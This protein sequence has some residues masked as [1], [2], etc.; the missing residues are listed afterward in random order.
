MKK[1]AVAAI[2]AVLIAGCSSQAQTFDAVPGQT[3][4]SYDL[5]GF[6]ALDVATGIQV[7]FTTGEAHSVTVANENG[8]W[9]KIIV[10]V[11]DDTLYLK[12][13]RTNGYKRNKEKFYVT[14]TA[15]AIYSLETSS[16]SNVTG[17]GMAGDNIYVDTSSGSSVTVAGIDA[18]AIEIDTSSGSSVKLSG[19][20]SSVSSDTSSGSSLRAKDLI[21][22]TA[23]LES[24]S[25]SSTSIT[26]KQSVNASASSGSTITVSGNPSDRDVNKSS[27]ASVNIRS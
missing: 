14:V 4:K 27:G 6:S 8:A 17:T 18:G 20:C 13:T 22:D 26:A 10:K 7:D 1:F 5:A 12:R 9:D 11:E 3:E 15:P 19:T 21:C 24:S 25:G 2:S 16:G 23:D